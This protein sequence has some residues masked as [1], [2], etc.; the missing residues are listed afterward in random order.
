MPSSFNG[1]R[2]VSREIWVFKGILVLLLPLGGAPVD[3]R[4]RRKGFDLG[5]LA[6]ILLLLCLEI[7]LLRSGFSGLSGL[8]CSLFIFYHCCQ[9][10][11]GGSCSV[12]EGGN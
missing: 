1:R 8:D 11:S 5:L 6:S 7:C 12:Y 3:K 9:L 2:G 4:Y 10:V